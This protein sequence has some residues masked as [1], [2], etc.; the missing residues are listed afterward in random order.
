MCERAQ[1]PGEPLA[2]APPEQDVTRCI[3]LRERE[4]IGQAVARRRGARRRVRPVALVE[5]DVAARQEVLVQIDEGSTVE[6]RDPQSVTVAA[7]LS[8]VPHPDAIMDRA[9]R[10]RVG[11]AADITG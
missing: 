5:L 10:I 8:Q 1:Q 4:R 2:W 7:R 11:V 9:S 3:P 6:Y